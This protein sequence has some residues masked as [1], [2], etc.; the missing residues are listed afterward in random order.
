MNTWK[1]TNGTVLKVND[2]TVSHI[3]NCLKMLRRNSHI[4]YPPAYE[5]YDTL[6]NMIK[7]KTKQLNKKIKMFEEELVKRNVRETILK[8]SKKELKRI[9]VLYEAVKNSK[10]YGRIK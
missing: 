8:L 4:R 10:G 9:L 1:T 5:Q 2:M 3:K 7:R 6:Y